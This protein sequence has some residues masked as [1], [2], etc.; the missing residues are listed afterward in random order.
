MVSLHSE[1][2]HRQG[3]IAVAGSTF[4]HRPHSSGGGRGRGGFSRGGGG[5]RGGGRRM[6]T[7]N[8]SQ[9]INKN[10]VETVEEILEEIK[11]L[12]IDYA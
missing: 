6:P 2:V 5:G 9:F 11:Q 12:A 8:P 7:F 4:T 10:P 1:I 3:P